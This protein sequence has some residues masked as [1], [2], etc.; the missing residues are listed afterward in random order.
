MTVSI[1]RDNDNLIA[2]WVCRGVKEKI[3]NLG[4]FLVTLGFMRGRKLIGG[5]IYHGISDNEL[6]WTVYTEN[7]AWCTRKILNFCFRFAFKD[8]NV[9]RISLLISRSNAKS[10]DFC[11]RLGFQIEGIKRQAR[12]NGEDVFLLGML[13]SECKFLRSEEK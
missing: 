6:F 10:L 12:E 7:P 5:L 4:G 9:R 8:L 11:T 13:K 1:I 2:A 3:E